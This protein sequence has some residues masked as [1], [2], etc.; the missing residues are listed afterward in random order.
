[1]APLGERDPLGSTQPGSHWTPRTHPE[2]LAELIE[3]FVAASG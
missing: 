1:M 3:Q 2:R